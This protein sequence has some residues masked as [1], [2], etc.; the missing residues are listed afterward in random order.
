M[1]VFVSRV[2]V[3]AASLAALVA[4]NV[5]PAAAAGTA[6]HFVANGDSAPAFFEA[7]DGTFI[8]VDVFRGGTPQNPQTMLFYTVCSPIPPFLCQ[9]GFGLI[10]NR[11]F[12]GSALTG[13]SL[14]TN[15]SAAANPGFS[16][17]GGS[18]G[19]I[20]LEQDAGF[21]RGLAGG[22]HPGI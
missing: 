17:F 13:M 9:E 21:Q 19:V 15:T 11:D 16:N 3:A 14:N 1:Q 4:S 6:S 12:Q 10:P 20:S 8:E 22:H 7:T 5:P 18:G 2:L